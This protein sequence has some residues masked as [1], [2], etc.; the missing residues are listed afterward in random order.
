MPWEKVGPEFKLD[1]KRAGMLV[2]LDRC[3]GCHSC[4]V[5]CKTEND[6]P[7]GDFRMRVR[8]LESP[9][10]KTI[11]FAPMLCMHCTDARLM[12]SSANEE[13]VMGSFENHVRFLKGMHPKVV[14]CSHHVGH[15]EHGLVFESTTKKTSPEE[16]L[17]KKL[18]DGGYKDSVW[19]AK[20]KGGI[21]GGVH[22][23]DAL[24]INPAPLIGG[25]NWY[26]N[27]CK[28]EKIS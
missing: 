23:N 16:G 17:S 4:S 22:I 21:G 15:W 28:I 24:P 25:Q 12:P 3:I 5:S 26:D 11:A 18:A 10:D 9:N 27:V 20:E 7:L 19:W 6:V 13:G 1:Y 8:Y 14:M 2:D